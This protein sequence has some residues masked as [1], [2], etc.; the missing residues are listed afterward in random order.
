MPPV[1]HSV[2]PYCIRRGRMGAMGITF[3]WTL[4]GGEWRLSRLNRADAAMRE[5]H[6]FPA[7]GRAMLFD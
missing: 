3:F 1:Y 4:L 7:A 5:R 2:E 6:W